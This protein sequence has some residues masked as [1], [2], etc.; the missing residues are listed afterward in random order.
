[1]KNMELK[2]LSNILDFFNSSF[3]IVNDVLKEHEKCCG[4]EHN[5]KEEN[6]KLIITIKC[7]DCETEDLF[8]FSKSKNKDEEF[9]I[10]QIEMDEK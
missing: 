9:M 2:Q 3:K 7:S 4:F 8:E 1:M 10:M 6:N 5:M